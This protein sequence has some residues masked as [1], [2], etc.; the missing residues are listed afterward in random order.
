MILV[1]IIIRLNRCSVNLVVRHLSKPSGIDP[2][3][4]GLLL[5]LSCV[6]M[7]IWIRI[8]IRP[9]WLFQRTGTLAAEFMEQSAFHRLEF[10][11]GTLC[12]S[13]VFRVHGEYNSCA[14]LYYCG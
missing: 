2:P 14:I 10:E 12:G 4:A 1:Q 5:I 9:Q 8:H 3:P 6:G 7:L 13:L 11:K